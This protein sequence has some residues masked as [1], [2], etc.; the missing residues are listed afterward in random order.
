M[1]NCKY[2]RVQ[3]TAV[4]HLECFVH[5]KTSKIPAYISIVKPTRCISV[6]NLFYWSNTVRVSDG[7]SAHRRELKTVHTATG[8]CQTDTADCLLASG[9]QYLFD[10]CLLQYAQSLTPDLGRK[11]RLKHVRCYSNKINLRH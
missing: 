2:S 9:Q 7:L 5:G 10:I 11:D 6:S 4:L 8:I 3:L 1:G